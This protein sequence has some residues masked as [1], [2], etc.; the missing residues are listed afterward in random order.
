MSSVDPCV[1]HDRQWFRYSMMLRNLTKYKAKVVISHDE[2]SITHADI[3]FSATGGGFAYDKETK[4][5]FETIRIGERGSRF[6]GGNVDTLHFTKRNVY[7]SVYLK[8]PIDIDE[9]KEI[10][11]GR[12]VDA[13][14]YDFN[15]LEKTEMFVEEWKDVDAAMLS[16]RGCSDINIL[17]K[18]KMFMDVE[19]WR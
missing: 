15:I 19:P 6:P 18:T 14:K 5:V 12:Y 17:E 10:Y 13:A 8:H 9:W 4:Q 2:T 16:Y 3:K 11:R 7:V 1:R